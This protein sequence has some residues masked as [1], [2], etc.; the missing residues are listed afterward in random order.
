MDAA[1][2]A[3]AGSRHPLRPDQEISPRQDVLARINLWSPDILISCTRRPG[4][5]A[6]IGT[7]QARIS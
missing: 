7:E 5:R 3:D 2:S 1:T 4:H 6:C